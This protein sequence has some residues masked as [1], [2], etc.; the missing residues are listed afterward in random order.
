MPRRPRSSEK[1]SAGRVELVTE[2]SRLSRP[3]RYRYRVLPQRDREHTGT[4]NPPPALPGPSLRLRASIRPDS[5]GR[6]ASPTPRILPIHREFFAVSGVKLPVTSRIPIQSVCLRRARRL[7]AFRID[8]QVL[9]NA[10][11]RASSLLTSDPKRRRGRCLRRCAL[12]LPR[13]DGRV[14]TLS[15]PLRTGN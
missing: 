4:P 12:R 15:K 10:P 7:V 6:G 3:I 5:Y 13:E 9:A 14:R 1:N 2:S 8:P 11:T